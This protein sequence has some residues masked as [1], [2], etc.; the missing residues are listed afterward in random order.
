MPIP[1]LS[2]DDVLPVGV[3]ECTLEEAVPRF[4]RFME[5]DRRPKLARQ[6][7]AYV[8]ELREAK[9]GKYL[10]VDGS[11][12]TGKTQPEDIDLLLVLRDDVD[13]DGPVPPFKYNVQSRSYL[14]RKYDFDFFFGFEHDDSATQMLS[15]FRRVKERPRLHKGMLKVVL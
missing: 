6:L 9:V 15:F 12:V 4:G 1:D 2:D 10:I 13:L 11:F 8:D 5:S 3:H 14:R 7:A